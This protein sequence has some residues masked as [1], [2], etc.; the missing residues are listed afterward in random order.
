MD[1]YLNNLNTIQYMNKRIVS[2]ILFLLI[3][4]SSGCEKEEIKSSPVH[5][6]ECGEIIPGIINI[7]FKEVQT[8][9][10]ISEIASNGRLAD[11]GEIKNIF[12]SAK[13]GT[14]NKQLQEKIG[15][16]KWVKL[17]LDKNTNFEQELI[18]WKLMPEVDQVS[19]D[20]YPCLIAVPN[21]NNIWVYK[22]QWYHSNTNEST[23]YGAWDADIDS[24][25]AWDIQ[26][27]NI[28]VAV[29]DTAIFWNHE[30]LIENIWQNLGEDAD[31]DGKVIQ[32]NGTDYIEYTD[33][34]G[35]IGNRSYMKHI[36][37]PDDINGIDDDGNGYIDDFI[38]WDF[39][40]GDNDPSPMP[41]Y[42]ERWHGTQ[43][44]GAGM[45]KGNNSIGGTGVC[46]NCKVI[47]MQ[48]G[49]VEP[50]AIQ[51]AAENG[52][53]VI[54]M[55]WFGT[56]NGPLSDSVDYAYALDIVLLTGIG[57][58][59]PNGA[60]NNFCKKENLI[61]IAGSTNEDKP[62]VSSDYNSEIGRYSDLGSPSKSIRAPTPYDHPLNIYVDTSGTSFGAPIAAGV[63]ALMLTEN[64]NLTPDEV[65][66][67]LLSSTDPYNITTPGRSSGIG[68]INAKN[69]LDL[70]LDSKIKGGFP[71]SIMDEYG[72]KINYTHLDLIGTAG[73]NNFENYELF[74]SIGHHTQ[75][76]ISLG[77]FQTEIEDSILYS[78]RRDEFPLGEIQFKLVVNDTKDQ[79]A[80]DIS[81]WIF[82][83]P[84]A[85]INK[86]ILLEEGW[87]HGSTL[88]DNIYSNDFNT[89][90]VIAYKEGNWKLD[91]NKIE[92]DEFE[93]NPLLGY[94]VYSDNTREVTLKGYAMGNT[95]APFSFN[96]DWN[97]ISFNETGLWGN[98]NGTYDPIFIQVHNM[99]IINNSPEYNIMDLNKDTIMR[100][101]PYWI[102]YILLLPPINHN[103]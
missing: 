59:A 40:H 57:N 39:Y 50:A 64:P 78:S 73:G 97:F 42:S 93:L 7:K 88:M 51:Y 11:P 9:T 22:Q 44:A 33:S 63:V 85:Q 98:I 77:V 27:G 19:F 100:G 81:E 69:A 65:K 23:Y 102:E 8:F 67:I 58:W 86:T 13:P 79:T 84:P 35:T 87:N 91:S 68:R 71:I 48:G 29:P 96:T 32:P 3:I 31:G 60:N 99:G 6:G 26:T 34:N 37:D 14:K 54:S 21:E 25:E 61:C 16:D 82:T 1:N 45:A 28:T 70:T 95:I 4:L 17:T 66:S 15:L 20:Y 2:I 36:F 47:A 43:T 56:I 53:K 24:T 101:K 5:E 41:R 74:Y 103:Q 55:S 89:S 62:W 38:G 94:L 52:A 92:G 80:Y 76:W 46:W 75:D 72:S 30:D 12:S 18:K 49:V 90:L 83:E 10:K